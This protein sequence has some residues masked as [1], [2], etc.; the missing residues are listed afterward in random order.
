MVKAPKV[1]LLPAILTVTEMERLIGITR[2]L[3][4][5]VFLLAI[6]SMGL[7][8]GET[9]SLQ[10]GDIDGQR[11]QIHVRRGKGYK[12]R[13][14]PLPDL[15]YQALRM[16]WSKHRNLCW[17]FPNPVHLSAFTMRPHTWTAAALKPP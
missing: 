17:L 11:K 5:R 3:R 16:L 4:Y 6:Y 1:K 15:T 13:F 9:L 10:A 12:D 8:L 2:K 7:R 14:V